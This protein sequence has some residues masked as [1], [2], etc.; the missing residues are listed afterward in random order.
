MPYLEI[1]TTTYPEGKVEQ[2]RL[3]RPD[4]GNSLGPTLAGELRAAL[5][6]L[7]AAPSKPRALVITADPVAK[8]GQRTWIAGGDLKEL[9]ECRSK[10][11]GERYA[12]SLSDLLTGLDALPLPVLLAVDGDAIG[13]GAEL[14]LGGDL[15]L[16][17]TDSRLIFKQLAV[18][19]ATGYGGA[20]RL[21]ELVGLS[22][23]QD[24]LFGTRTL[25]AGEALTL[26]LVH[27]VCADSTALADAVELRLQSLLR[28]EPQ[29]LSTQKRMLWH[30]VR[31][32]PGVA[33]AAEAQ[34]FR[35]LWGNPT[36]RRFLDDFTAKKAGR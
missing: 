35:E 2:W 11:D 4:R 26:G 36:H 19:L 20:R 18:G 12:L 7:V 30:A 34:L 22:R 21:V 6:A 16:M 3:V 24:L 9:A 33:R 23:T 15:R 5:A 14:A 25:T 28:L 32:H 29:A 10:D 17:T 8:G 1:S 31:S 13:G 27:Q